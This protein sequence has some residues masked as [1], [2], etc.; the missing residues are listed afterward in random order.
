M[1]NVTIIINGEIHDL[2]YEDDLG[3]LYDCDL[4][5]LKRVCDESMYCVCRLGANGFK[6]SCFFERRLYSKETEAKIETDADI[7]AE[8]EYEVKA[9]TEAEK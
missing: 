5:S 4:C 7:E 2:V 8:I 9:E 6:K 1:K 3:G